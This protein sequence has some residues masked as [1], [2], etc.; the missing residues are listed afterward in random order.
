MMLP[1]LSIM[2]VEFTIF[3]THIAKVGTSL[4]KKWIISAIKFILDG[5][6]VVKQL[7]NW[8]IIREQMVG[9]YLVLRNLMV[10]IL[11]IGPSNLLNVE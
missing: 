5:M 7:V 9:P 2:M 6:M 11:F 1:S 3:V 4:V 8:I 10:V